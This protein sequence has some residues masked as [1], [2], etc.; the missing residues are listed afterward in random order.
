VT[1]GTTALNNWTVAV[2]LPAG[3]AVSTSWSAQATGTSGT[4][5]FANASYNGKVTAGGSTEFGFQGTGTPPAGT[6]VCTAG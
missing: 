4:V 1:A 6:Q 2:T 5:R 3:S